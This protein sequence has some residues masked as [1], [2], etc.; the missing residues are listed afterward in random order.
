MRQIC[1]TDLLHGLVSVKTWLPAACK[2]PAQSQGY[3]QTEGGT[4]QSWWR[5]RWWHP[6][7]SC[8]GCIIKILD[9]SVWAPPLGSCA[10]PGRSEGRELGNQQSHKP[11]VSSPGYPNS[12]HS[13]WIPSTHLRQSKNQC[14]PRG[15][16]EVTWG[17]GKTSDIN[18]NQSGDNLNIQY[19][20]PIYPING[21][22]PPHLLQHMQQN[23][24]CAVSTGKNSWNHIVC[25]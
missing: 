6:R 22:M 19:H 25:Q 14:S 10:W 12:A 2:L 7:V 16:H 8:Q 4:Q 24:P 23:E 15:C 1:R 17:G 3:T 9:Q 13:A 5:W 20:F 11:W 21:N 18:Y